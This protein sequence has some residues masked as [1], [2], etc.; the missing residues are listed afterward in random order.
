MNR[1]ECAQL[2]RPDQDIVGIGASVPK[3]SQC[4]DRTGPGVDLHSNIPHNVAWTSCAEPCCNKI[5]VSECDNHVVCNIHRSTIRTSRTGILRAA[6][7]RCV[8]PCV[9]F[10]FIGV[11]YDVRATVTT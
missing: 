3:V 8:Q 10:G 5:I 6:R 1:T 4:N 11:V 9:G 2:S 7:N